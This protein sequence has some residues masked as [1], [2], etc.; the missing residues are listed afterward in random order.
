M[1]YGYA[2]EYDYAPPTQLGATLEAKAVPGLFLAG[3]INGT[4]GYEEAAAQG[5]IAGINAARLVRGEGPFV[6]D[7][8]QGYIGVLVDDL[9]T[10]GVDEPYRMFTSRAEYRL[11]LRSDNADLRL[12]AMG[13]SI[14]LVDDHRWA[15]F[16]ARKGRNRPALG[17]VEVD[18]GR[19]RHPRNGPPPP[20]DDLGTTWSR[21][22][23]PCSGCPTTRPPSSR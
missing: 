10:R 8:S 11:L 16:E 4:T 5:L 14:G 20:A 2:V 15:R 7:R 6:V 17:R 18:P 9:V 23:P 3:Q 13:R 21:S 1:R 12:T 19:R 22:T